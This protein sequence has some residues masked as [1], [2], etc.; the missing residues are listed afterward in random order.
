MLPKQLLVGKL[1]YAVVSDE[2]LG[3]EEDNLGTHRR[4]SLT[5]TIDTSFP[6]P[7]QVH[8]LWHE[9]FHAISSQYKMEL[10]EK[11]CDMLASGVMALLMDNPDLVEFTTD[12][13]LL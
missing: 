12:W 1:P 6:M 2:R 13:E 4:D 11:A 7:I 10:D 8:T 5:I 3:V 9:L